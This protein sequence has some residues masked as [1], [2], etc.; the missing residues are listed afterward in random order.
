[1]SLASR[2]LRGGAELPQPLLVSPVPPCSDVLALLCRTRNVHFPFIQARLH[3]FLQSEITLFPPFKYT[4]SPLCFLTPL[5]SRTQ[6]LRYLALPRSRAMVC[7]AAPSLFFILRTPNYSS[8]LFF[9]CLNASHSAVC[10]TSTYCF[11]QAYDLAGSL[12]VCPRSVRSRGCW[13][14]GADSPPRYPVLPHTHTAGACRG[15]MG[16]KRHFSLAASLTWFLS[17]ESSSTG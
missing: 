4:P 16:A 14:A 3:P 10:S 9:C 8:L 1:M 2:S 13:S 6:D 15:E 17:G 7:G 12:G 5:V 11:S